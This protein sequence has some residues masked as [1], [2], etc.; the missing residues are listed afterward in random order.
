MPRAVPFARVALPLGAFVLVAGLVVGCS[1][2]GGE[3]AAPPEA[4]AS[5]QRTTLS[6]MDSGTPIMS[7]MTSVG[8]GRHSAA[9]RSTASPS[10][11]V[12]AA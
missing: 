1:S 11:A 10:P 5:L 12:P 7:A 2:G 4:I 9:V 3:Q 8:S 6:N